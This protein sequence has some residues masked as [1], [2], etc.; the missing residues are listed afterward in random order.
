M[1]TESKTNKKQG[2]FRKFCQETNAPGFG[3]LVSGLK[4]GRLVTVSFTTLRNHI[5]LLVLGYFGLLLLL[6]E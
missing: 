4:W 6:E 1:M 3:H 2:I 5:H